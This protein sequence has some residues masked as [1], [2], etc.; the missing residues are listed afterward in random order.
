MIVRRE[1]V[2]LVV[3]TCAFF[4]PA[5]S[6]AASKEECMDSHGRGQDMR[7]RGQ[8]VRARQMFVACAQS[9]CPALVQ[10]D[11]ARLGEELSH[12]VPTVTFGARDA[13]AGDLPNTTVYVDDVLMTSRLDDGRSH[14]VDPGKH[15][16]RFVHGGKETTVKIV[17]NQG[18]KGRLVVATFVEEG[19]SAPA[20]SSS[21]S[22]SSESSAPKRSV[23]PLVVAGV[24]GAAAITGGVL[25]GIGMS[26]VPGNC[27]S[28]SHECAAPPGDSSIDKAQSSMSLANVGVIIGGVG[29]VTL[30][31]GLVWYFATP[32]TSS[33]RGY[34]PS[35]FITF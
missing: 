8:L 27:N 22:S 7:D 6:M 19:A 33:A 31:S 15:M 11:C 1:I 25:F 30:V 4:S 29:L 24:G 28:G 10:G 35:P 32:P 34:A 3:A 5:T 12:L 2:S 23:F 17:L 9:S 14:E 18:E 16:V 20:S 13:A 21:S 26:G